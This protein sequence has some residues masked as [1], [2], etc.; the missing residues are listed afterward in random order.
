MIF[1]KWA[2]DEV[3]SQYT[4]WTPHG[5]IQET[6]RFVQVCLDGSSENKYTWIIETKEESKAIGCFA[7]S[8]VDCKV[9]IGYL[10]IKNQWGKGYMTEAVAAFINEVFKNKEI[11]R[12]WGRL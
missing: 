11:R 2:Q 5:E 3:I 12:V 8:K 9:E 6:E 4:T 1:E 7:A 10:V